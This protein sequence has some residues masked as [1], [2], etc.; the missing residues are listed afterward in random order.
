MHVWRIRIFNDELLK[1]GADVDA[2]NKDGETA[3]MHVS[4]V[5]CNAMHK[6]MLQ[7]LLSFGADINVK[8][9]SLKTP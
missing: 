7:L 3:L 2:K 4:K 1:S 6:D 5:G 8:D 9:A